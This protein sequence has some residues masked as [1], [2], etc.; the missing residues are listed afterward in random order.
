MKPVIP[1]FRECKNSKHHRSEFQRPLRAARWHSK[2]TFPANDKFPRSLR[3]IIRTLSRGAARIKD[4]THVAVFSESPS[5]EFFNR[6]PHFPLMNTN[7]Q[8]D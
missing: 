6:T 1:A 3:V 7:R 4:G 2:R 8:R 5:A